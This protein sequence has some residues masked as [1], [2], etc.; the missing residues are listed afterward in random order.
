MKFVKIPDLHVFDVQLCKT[1]TITNNSKFKDL[2]DT[3]FV[4]I[5]ILGQILYVCIQIQ[6]YPLPHH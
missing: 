3:K 4:Q 1:N 5:D 2:N 6:T